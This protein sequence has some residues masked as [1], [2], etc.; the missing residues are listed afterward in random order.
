MVRRLAALN[1]LGVISSFVGA[2]LL[3]YAL[4]MTSLNY[5]LV[6]TK[7]HGVAICLNDKLVASGFGG[8]IIMSDDPC[9]QAIGPSR[10]PVIE[11]ERPAF[12]AWGLRLLWVGFFLQLPAAFL[13]TF[14]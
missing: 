6:E 1:L 7:E 9:P 12:F 10:A 13:A 5:K 8:G 4:T 11:A 3:T 2:L 14:G